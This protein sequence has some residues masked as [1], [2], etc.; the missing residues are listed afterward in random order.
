MSKEAQNKLVPK[1]RFPEFEGPWN[2][3]EGDKLFE[4]ISDK[5]HNSDLPI[6]AITQEQ[7]AIPRNLIDY[8]VSVTD[9]SVESYKVVQIGDFII[10]L[11]SFQGGIEYSEYVGLC[12]P[13]YIILRKKRSDEMVND[14]YRHY[15]KSKTFIRDLNRNL[16]G[17]R[18]GKMVSYK[19]FSEIESPMP[20]P[21]EQQKIADCLSSLDELIAAHS[22]QLEAL[23]AHKKGLLQQLFPAEGEKVPRRRFT[24]FQNGGEW[25]E[26]SIGDFIVE[27]KG[28]APLTPS[29]F[30]PFSHCEVIPK[31]AI[32]GGVWLN[33]DSDNPTFCSEDFYKRN[34]QS[35]VDNTFLITSLRDLVPSG[36]NIGYIVKYAGDKKYILAQ[37]VYGIKLKQ[38][39]V[40]EFLIHYSNTTF[41]RKLVNAAMV[42]STQ[43]HIRNS[44]FFK[45]PMTI[46]SFKEQQKIACCL[47]SVDERI[48]AQTEKITQ[49]KLHK[50][51]L[52]QGL[53]PTLNSNE[54]G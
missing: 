53:F 22:R 34:P 28:G 4:Q 5:E 44:E 29:D 38:T 17:I 43:V 49:L 19:Q 8:H 31:K 1:W 42:G 14:F 13:A 6:L 30:V 12:S 36:P 20:S 50:K 27:H 26:K 52:I 47:S 11:R 54:N 3:L 24:E 7:G 39:L 25:E 51:G 41:Y 15:F 9:K 33:L 35:V 2:Y 23:K 45:L 46:P 48:T 37:G 40:P 16:E 32:A 21:A 10:S 18:D